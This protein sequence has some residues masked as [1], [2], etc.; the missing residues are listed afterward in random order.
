MPNTPLIL[1]A[2]T[3]VDGLVFFVDG[4]PDF[5]HRLQT[6]TGT[7]PLEDGTEVT[8]LAVA[9]PPEIRLTGLVTDMD[10]AQR[11]YQAWSQLRRLHATSRLLSVASEWGLYENMLIIR[12]EGVPQGRG[13]RCELEL[14][15]VLI[16]GPPGVSS[17][18]R[19]GPAEERSPE[20]T[21][22]RAPRVALLNNPQQSA[23][24]A[25]SSFG[26]SNPQQSAVGARSSFGLSLKVPDAGDAE[27][28]R[29]RLARAALLNNPQQSAVGARSSFGLSR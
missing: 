7:E 9:L 12:A 24:G 1:S 25:R 18:V 3:L 27:L 20:V 4:Y 22:G 13:L 10:G 11:P 8:D 2:A 5:L 14:R 29:R 19:T 28:L 6:R 15:E 21:Q 16:A 17:I 26:L 23:V